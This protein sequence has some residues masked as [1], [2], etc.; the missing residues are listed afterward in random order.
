VSQGTVLWIGLLV[1]LAALFLLTLRRLSVLVRRTRDLE[2][3]QRALEG[4]SNRLS[5][6]VGPLVRDLDDLRRRAGDPATLAQRI[7]DAK[8]ELARLAAEGRS[9]AAPNGLE[10]LG[11]AMAG[12]L[13][14]A[15][16]AATTV[17]TGLSAMSDARGGRELEAQTSLKR[18]AL[19]LRNATET[20]DRLLAQ[21]RAV[22]PADLARGTGLPTVTGSGTLAAYR[23]EDDEPIGR[24]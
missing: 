20:Y 4:F 10:S 16:R 19:N 6:T 3:F 9:L 8:G 21:A 18:G 22:R 5:T 23:S 12:E 11:A 1:L 2:R 14:R 13:E 24:V 15:S 17:A 7:P